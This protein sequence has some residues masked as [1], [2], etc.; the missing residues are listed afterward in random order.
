MRITRLSIAQKSHPIS[1]EQGF[2]F[3]NLALYAS[4][5]FLWGTSWFPLKMQVGVVAPHVSLTWRF[6]IAS[7]VMMVLVMVTKRPLQFSFRTHL[8][9]LLLGIFLFSTNFALFYY[10]AQWIASG[11]LSVVFSLASIVNIGF[12]LILYGQ[13]P[14]R[15]VLFGAVLGISGVAALFWPEIMAADADPGT[16]FGLLLCFGGTVSFCIGNLFSAQM[17]RSG[18]S[19]MSGNA[20]GMVYGT[21]FSALIAF[22]SGAKFIIEPTASYILS[23]LWL[24]LTGTVFAF[25][26]YLTLLGRIGSARAGYATIMFPIV[27]LLV[28]TLF[29]NYQWTLLGLAGVALA[30]AGNGLVL[31]G[32]KK[33]V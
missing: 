5:V 11:L 20:W 25:W 33:A 12:A 16:L 10:G 32:R 3:Q 31:S 29:E 6:L 22:V 28:S 26:C 24:S 8:R 27:A 1:S 15:R 13:I 9:F 17:Q 2:G 4:I 23:L 30:L 7:V 14:T 18:I 21:A 19:V